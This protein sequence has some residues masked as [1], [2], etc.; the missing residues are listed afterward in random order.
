MPVRNKEGKTKPVRKKEEN[1][2][3]CS[4]TASKTF[5][6]GRPLNAV[7]PSAVAS[8]FVRK[9]KERNV[10][11]RK[12]EGKKI[13]VENAGTKERSKEIYLFVMN[14]STSNS[15][16]RSGPGKSGSKQK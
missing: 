10:P 8:L 16:K 3:T 1:I 7:S 14:A 12:K 6:A 13:P 9:K 2:Y 5:S 11:V 15:A 4:S